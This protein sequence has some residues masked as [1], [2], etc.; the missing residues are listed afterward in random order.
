[1]W[2][3]SVSAFVLFLFF[4]STG[5]A[6]APPRLHRVYPPRPYRAFSL[7]VPAGWRFHNAS[8]VSDHMT[9][10]WSGPGDPH[11]RAEVVFSGCSGCVAGTKPRTPN[12]AGA[13]P[14]AVCT[15]RISPYVLAFTAP[16][17]KS[18]PGYVDNGLVI[19]THYPDGDIAGFLR[20]DLWLPPSKNKLARAILSSF[21][22]TP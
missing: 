17:E 10:L 19:V 5:S 14:D 16:S 11:A 9:Y 8:Y 18:E 15:Y 13:A 4:A 3:A 12:P 1:M 2:P 22:A 20:I 7:M 21:R 6:A